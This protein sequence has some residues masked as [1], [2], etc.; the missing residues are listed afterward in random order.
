MPSTRATSALSMSG[1]MSVSGSIPSPTRTFS[2]RPARRVRTS[3]ATLR[4]TRIGEPVMQNS[5]PKVVIPAASSGTM[6]SRSASSNTIIGVLPPSS[7]FIRLRVAAPFAGRCARPW[8]Y[9]CS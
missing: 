8:C 6:V 3:S 2:S 4:C 7:R 5:P 1:P 9:R